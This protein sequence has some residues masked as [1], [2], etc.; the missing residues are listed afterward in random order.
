MRFKTFTLIAAASLGLAA[1]GD[2]VGEQALGGAAIGAGIAAITDGDI[3]KG[4]AIGAGAN[5]VACNTEIAD[6]N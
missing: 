2:N 4:A 3:A 5:V 1:C 6:C